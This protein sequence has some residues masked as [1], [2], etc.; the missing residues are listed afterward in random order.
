[1][2]TQNTRESLSRFLN[3][4][5][6]NEHFLNPCILISGGWGTGKSYFLDEY[7]RNINNLKREKTVQ[8]ISVSLFKLNSIQ[9]LQNE[10]ILKLFKW[11]KHVKAISGAL[12][13]LKKV[14]PYGEY[15]PIGELTSLLDYKEFSN[16]I[17]CFDDF[18]RVSERL[19]FNSL[20]GYIS[21]LKERKQ[22]KVIIIANEDFL[23]RLEHNRKKDPD[24]KTS[25]NA[26]PQIW[27]EFKEK[28]V[29]YQFKFKPT[30]EENIEAILKKPQYEILQSIHCGIFIELCDKHSEQNIRII[31]RALNNV[32]EFS[33]TLSRIS[34]KELLSKLISCVFS[35][36]LEA[37]S[38]RTNGQTT[39]SLMYHSIYLTPSLNS[40]IRECVLSGNI[41]HTS[42]ST[43]FKQYEKDFHIEQEISKTIENY[44]YNIH[45]SKE[46]T[47]ENITKVLDTYSSEIPINSLIH[48]LSF[49]EYISLEYFDKYKCLFSKR[50]RE[51]LTGK[52][53]IDTLQDF[54][55]EIF[56]K[57]IASSSLISIFKSIQEEVTAN[58]I[59]KIIDDDK[60]IVILIDKITRKNDIT[61]L[62]DNISK[63]RWKYLISHNIISV[64]NIVHIL[65][66]NHSEA[67][68]LLIEILKED[69]LKSDLEIKLKACGLKFDFNVLFAEEVPNG[70]AC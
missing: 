35:E 14:I 70:K 28:I 54:D 60:K 37:Y 47:I 63:L 18:E 55:D 44:Y 50:I 46:I 33:D 53:S 52:I 64:R 41:N 23:E 51:Q 59:S 21:D 2:V 32:I 16:V 15:F 57:Q 29:D 65:N 30:I 43:E 67:T 4:K 5:L 42:F 61:S 56:V 58:Y 1:M 40:A 11:I 9:E 34:N 45:T 62:L 8:I 22:C 31:S 38:E 48:A 24:N 7:S 39:A 27:H 3:T 66:N 19:D 49:L 69:Y 6:F 10:I 25:I 20:L 36:S 12:K 68:D 13:Y 17:I 26:K